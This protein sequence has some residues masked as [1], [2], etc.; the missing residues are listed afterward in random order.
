M[1][2]KISGA[3]L[4]G[5]TASRFNGRMKSKIVVDG[6]TIISRILTVIKDIFEEIII[7]T[8]N[9]EEFSDFKFCIIVHDEILNAGPLGGIHAAMKASSFDAVFIFAG[10]MPF[11]DRNV[12]L[13]MIEACKKSDCDALIPKVGEYIEP[14]HSIY[15]QTII[16]H[17]EA[18]L[19][20]GRSKAV[21][22]FIELINVEFLQYENTEIIKRA[23]TNINSP[24][25]LKHQ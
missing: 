19:K 18:Y 24:T 7:V 9:P 20:S 25:D 23:F 21:R 2:R 10:D 5:G 8:N 6:E 12:I 11:I 15:R 17:L 13:K 22:D 4:A 1:A 14:L 16:N 3:I